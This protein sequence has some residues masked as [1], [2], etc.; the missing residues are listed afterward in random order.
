MLEFGRIYWFRVTG[1]GE[2]G[3]PEIGGGIAR[4]PLDHHQVSGLGWGV[5]R[6]LHRLKSTRVAWPVLAERL[7]RRDFVA[8]AAAPAR[9][10]EGNGE[11][12][13]LADFQVHF[14]SVRILRHS[15]HLHFDLVW[16]MSAN[17]GVRP[18]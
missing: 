6:E 12:S 2:V 10:I 11:R 4:Q 9:P 5:E 14:Y 3:C 7:Q 18:L 8:P 1:Q 13:G 17:G 16:T 15:S